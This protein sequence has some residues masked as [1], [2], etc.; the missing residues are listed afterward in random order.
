[1]PTDVLDKIA[2]VIHE[3]DKD[4]VTTSDFK[5]IIDV[6]VQFAKEGR[7]LT[8]QEM[9]KVQNACDRL[10][11]D[12]EQEHNQHMKEM[13]AEMQSLKTSLF[14][15]VDTKLST[16]D[17]LKTKLVS[18]IDEKLGTVKNGEDGED[19]ISPDPIEVASMV[20]AEMPD[21]LDIED[22]RNGLEVLPDGEKL[23]I[24]AI[25]D[26][27][28][29]LDELE[30]KIKRVS[31]RGNAVISSGGVG[32]RIVKIHDLSDS[33]NGSTKT[34]SLPA[35]W[36]V[37]SVHTSSF[38]NILRPTIDYTVDGTLMQITFTSE[39]DAST[40]LATGQTVIIQYAES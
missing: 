2:S 34:F 29:R 12:M 38:P 15:K 7:D 18:T 32:G 35:F 3:L 37:L 22:V 5:E 27:P 17:T 20:L 31:N 39:I 10:M 36:R 28:K 23:E 16:L 33:L 4:R 30:N 21:P 13:K 6:L 9:I 8:E 26:L 24:N 25:Q 14:D 11:S 19:G 40:T 1:M